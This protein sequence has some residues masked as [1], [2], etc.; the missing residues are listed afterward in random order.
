MGGKNP[1]IVAASADVDAAAAGIA[2]SAYGFSGQKCSACSRAIVVDSVHDELVERLA[3][4][5]AAMAVGDPADRDAFTGPVVDEHAVA[6]FA[7]A[8]EEAGRDGQVV[9]GGRALDLPGHFVAPT[10]VAGLPAGH[11]LTR[12]ELF[13]PFVA[14]TRV[15]SFDEA[16]AEANAIDYGLTAGVFS[17]EQAELDRF[18]DEIEAGVVYVNRRAGATTGAWPGF[19]SFC[20][21]KSSGS[22]GKG[23]LGPYY[24]QQFMREQSRTIVSRSELHIYPYG[25]TMLAMARAATTTD[26]FNA[27]AEPRRREI[28]EALA[29]GERSVNDLV[30]ALGLGQPQVSK[31]LRVLREVGAVEVRD[32]GRQR[33]YRVNGHALK[34]IHDWVRTFE[35]TWS[36]RFDALDDVLDDL[37]RKGADSD[38]D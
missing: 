30:E 38:G 8:V 26:A 13:V 1:T 23:G 33:L 4:Q 32:A 21:W 7:A 18:L 19:Q 3:A 24:V 27:I 16:L 31:H 2:A 12:A 9:A 22:T 11:R 10:V 29:G 14:V 37:K 17:R 36:D 5:A 20:G 34:P 15:G 35:A 28:L 25:Y 6:R